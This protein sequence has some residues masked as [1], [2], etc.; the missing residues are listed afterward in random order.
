MIAHGR[1]GDVALAFSTSGGSANIRAALAEARRRGLVTIA[2]LGYDGGQIAADSL[3]DHVLV[4]PSEYI[5]RIQEAHATAYHLLRELVERGSP[6]ARPT[7][8][9]PR[10]VSSRLV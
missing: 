6:T 10:R 9:T 5:P 4:A 7:G 1:E 8:A 2:V 3:A